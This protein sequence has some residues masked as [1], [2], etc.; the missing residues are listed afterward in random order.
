MKKFLLV[1][2]PFI[3][4]C[5]Q[6][7]DRDL[8][9]V[10]VSYTEATA[11]YG[12]LDEIRSTP[13]NESVR[14]IEDPGKIYISESVILIGEEEKGIH[15]I[16]NSNEESPVNIGFLNVPGNREFFVK[17]DFIYAETYYDVV[18]IDISNPRQA[19]IVSRAENVFQEPKTDAEG[20][21]LVG[22][23]FKDVTKELNEG[24]DLYNDILD[25]QFVY[26]DFARNIIPKS[27]VPASFAGNSNGTSGTVNRVT[28][29]HDRVY[30][31][32]RTDLAILNNEGSQL[33]KVDNNFSFFG[34]DMET[35]FPYEDKLFI[36]SRSSMDIYD[37]TDADQPQHVYNFQHATSCDP[38]LADQE[39]A[40]VTLRTADF[41][42]CPGDINA[43][44]TL[45]ITELNRP[46]QTSEVTM[47]SP[48]GMTLIGDKLYVAEG[49]QGLKIFDVSDRHNPTILETVRDVQ[50]YDILAHPTKEN[51]ILVA[52]P[53]GLS[54]F[55]VDVENK[56]TE[57]S[58]IQY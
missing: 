40:Y 46:T 16:D 31:I 50:A 52:T 29:A 5:M 36:G 55:E 39:A 57:K 10:N 42:P 27:A 44:V 9:T 22:F 18:K 34:W 30:I 35:V 43:L 8:G 20:E 33:Q 25:D 56:F 48:Y 24:S 1:L 6:S 14:T 37:V 53:Q 19:S 4:F 32:N 58:T 11:I 21:T 47:E 15:V 12:D 17:D 3:M 2:T 38:V 54:Q 41:S 49:E 51:L 23:S 7:C 13:I 28:V 26:Y 45:D